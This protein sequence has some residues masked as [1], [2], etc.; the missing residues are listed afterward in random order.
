MEEAFCVLL[1]MN[2]QANKLPTNSASHVFNGRMAASRTVWV[3]MRKTNM[4]RRCEINRQQQIGTGI[5][6]D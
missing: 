4:R 1:I 2:P 6:P 3:G 5:G